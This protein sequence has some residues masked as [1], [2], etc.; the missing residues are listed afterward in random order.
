MPLDIVEGSGVSKHAVLCGRALAPVIQNRRAETRR[1]GPVEATARSLTGRRVVQSAP[2]HIGWRSTED[3]S[4]EAYLSQ[5]L[6]IFE[7]K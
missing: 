4:D 2:N 5:A 6:S 7:A 3:V 1:A